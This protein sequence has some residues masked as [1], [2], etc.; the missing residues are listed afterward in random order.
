[1]KELIGLGIVEVIDKTDNISSIKDKSLIRMG[2]KGNEN[3]GY[4]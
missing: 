3:R 4:P 1:M 2:R